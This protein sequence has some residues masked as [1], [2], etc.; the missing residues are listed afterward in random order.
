MFRPDWHAFNLD[1][2]DASP[3]S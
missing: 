1:P 2:N 3:S